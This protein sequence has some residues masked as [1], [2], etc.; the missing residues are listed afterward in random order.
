M[1][2]SAAYRAYVLEQ[3]AALEGVCARAMFG[4]VGLYCDA[5]FFALIADDTLYL[6]VDDHSRGDY[7]ARGMAPFRPYAARP[8]LSRRYYAAPAE[9]LE[10]A[11]ELLLWARRAL[12]AAA[13]PASSRRGAPARGK[14]SAQR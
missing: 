13:A 14:R 1:A 11:S 4:G 8:H 9:V 5:R 6:R 10:D 3:L 7:T 12:A 2:V